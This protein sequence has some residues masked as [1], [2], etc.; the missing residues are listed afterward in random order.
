MKKLRNILIKLIN[1]YKDSADIMYGYY[2]T[3]YKIK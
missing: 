2:Y 1:S 3:N